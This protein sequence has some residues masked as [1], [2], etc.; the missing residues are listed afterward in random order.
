[1]KR[2][3]YETANFKGFKVLDRNAPD[4]TMVAWVRDRDDAEVIAEALNAQPEY[5]WT[6][7]KGVLVISDDGSSSTDI[8]TTRAD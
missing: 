3:Y 4:G 8:V 6:S 2:F 7:V 5:P 1:M